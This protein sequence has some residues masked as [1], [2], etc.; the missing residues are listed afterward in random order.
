MVTVW[1]YFL[2]L[3]WLAYILFSALLLFSRGF[4]LSRDVLNLFSSC[5][6]KTSSNHCDFVHNTSTRIRGDYI[7]ECTEENVMSEHL[8]MT[9]S[10]NLDNLQYC[11]NSTNKV[12]ILIID[13]LRYDFMQYDNN[14]TSVSDSL[15]SYKNKLP[16]INNLLTKYANSSRLYKFVADPPTTTMQRLNALTTGSLPTFIDIGSNFA[17]PEINEDNLIDQI[18]HLQKKVVFM[19]DDTWTSLYPKRFSRQFPFPSFNVWD[20]DT[21]D[22]GIKCH[23]IKEIKQGDWDVI[24][25]HYLGVDHC[26]HRYG[27]EHREMARKLL[28]MN[29][30]IR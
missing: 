9:K 12:I 14:Y 7:L 3:V 23:L 8:N 27:P 6:S 28:E 24:I 18:V 25:A 4:F 16:V 19:G 13:A 10:S 11:L 29:Q 17:T 1:K 30:Y 15:P 2:F 21:V 20:L 5:K 26:G 22:S